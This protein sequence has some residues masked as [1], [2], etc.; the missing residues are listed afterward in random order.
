MTLSVGYLL[1]YGGCSIMAYMKYKELTQYFN[2]HQ[3]LDINNLP[4]FVRDY[5]SFNERALFGYATHNDTF[6]LTDKKLLVFDVS[7]VSTRKTIHVFPFNSISS[8]AVEFKKNKA[9]ILLSMDSGYQVRLNF[10]KM[11]PQDKTKFRQMYMILVNYIC[12]K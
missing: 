1:D 6:V 3:E 12:S 8:S 9:A 5:L 10:V 11:L 4:E 7:D 2:F